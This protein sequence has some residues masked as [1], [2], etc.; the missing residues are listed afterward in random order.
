MSASA[1]LRRTW[2]GLGEDA[3]N[4]NLILNIYIHT[5]GNQ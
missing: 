5:G 3:S 1:F 4:R 2:Q